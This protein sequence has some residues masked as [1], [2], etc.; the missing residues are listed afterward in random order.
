MVERNEYLA[1]NKGLD[2]NFIPV[3]IAIIYVTYTN[4][5]PCRHLPQ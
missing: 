1:S 4:I 2:F 5:E 3:A